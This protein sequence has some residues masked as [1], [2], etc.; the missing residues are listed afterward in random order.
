MYT[1]FRRGACRISSKG[2]HSFFF[3][4]GGGGGVVCNGKVIVAFRFF[5]KLI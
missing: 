3:F 1:V 5:I 4:L 2:T